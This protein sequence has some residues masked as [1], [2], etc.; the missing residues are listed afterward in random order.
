MTE[1]I[2]PDVRATTS[3]RW[4]R[5]LV[6]LIVGSLLVW[7]ALAYVVMPQIWKSYVR[8]HPA[9]DDLPGITQT[10]SGIPGDPINVALIGTESDLVKIMIAA[11]WNPA[12]ALS[13]KSSLR[14]AVDSVFKRPDPDAPVSNL[15]L[16]GRKE[17][18]AFEQEAG[19][20]P[21][22]R[23]HVRFWRTAKDDPDGRPVWVGSAVYDERVGVSRRT[24]Q[25]THVTAPDVDKERDYLFACLEKTGDLS[26]RYVVD[27]FHKVHSGKNGGGDPWT[28]D[29]RLFVG[30][31][32]AAKFAASAP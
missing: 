25:V 12:D 6:M 3:P 16:F 2:L 19:D 32:D 7:A 18:L 26:E 29:G 31:I 24:G 15:Y 1:P 23:H 4:R 13:L 8:R 11:K 5:R 14:I 27:D 22:H 9:L 10:G 20:S 17:D 21:R 30:V 28:T